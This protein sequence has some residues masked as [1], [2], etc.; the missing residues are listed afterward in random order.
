MMFSFRYRLNRIGT[1]GRSCL[2]VKKKKINKKNIY[3]FISYKT[4]DI[5]CS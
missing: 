4:I 1:N 2:D 3:I 5:L